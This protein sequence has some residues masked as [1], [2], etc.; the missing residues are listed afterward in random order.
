[1]Q[2]SRKHYTPQEKLAILKLHLVDKM[3]ISDVC[4]EY[5]I[6]P[7]M[8]YK[9][10]KQL[11]ENGAAAFERVS[12]RTVNAHER[13]IAAL[14]AKIQQKNEV[15]AELLQEHVELKKELGEL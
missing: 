7:T 8:F 6:L 14:E 2:K 3:P 1:M 13:Q 12:K 9:W 11:F 15:V 4:D 5:Q 10:Q